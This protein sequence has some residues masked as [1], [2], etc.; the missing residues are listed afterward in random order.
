MIAV[1][2]LVMLFLLVPRVAGIDDGGSVCFM[3]PIYSVTKY[4]MIDWENYGEYLE[5]WGVEIF[6]VTV[7]YSVE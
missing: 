1:V 2:I 6:G 3:T 4:H 5:G 7:Y